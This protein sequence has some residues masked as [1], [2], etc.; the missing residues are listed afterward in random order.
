MELVMLDRKILREADKVYR[1]ASKKDGVLYKV[2]HSRRKNRSEPYSGR[3]ILE[4]YENNLPDY[5]KSREKAVE[6]I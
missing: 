2:A 3:K 1:E 5:H 4:A 6:K